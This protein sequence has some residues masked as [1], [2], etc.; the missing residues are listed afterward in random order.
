MHNCRFSCARIQRSRWD[1]RWSV[2]ACVLDRYRNTK[3]LFWIS[4]ANH[5]RDGWK[6]TACRC[7]T[8]Q[9][10]SRST[11]KKVVTLVPHL[12]HTSWS[13][14]PPSNSPTTARGSRPGSNQENLSSQGRAP[15]G[16]AATRQILQNKVNEQ[17]AELQQLKGVESLKC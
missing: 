3:W 9:V 12:P 10:K 1:Q 8:P 2:H 11:K 6:A 13:P 7:Q 15:C 4:Y 16:P 14:M 5:S 17:E